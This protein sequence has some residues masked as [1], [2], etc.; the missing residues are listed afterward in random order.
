MDDNERI[1]DEHFKNPQIGDCFHEFYS[2]YLDVIDINDLGI[3]TLTTTGDKPQIRTFAR[4]SKNLFASN[5]MY[6]TLKDK[7]PWTYARTEPSTDMDWEEHKSDS[8]FVFA[9]STRVPFGFRIKGSDEGFSEHSYLIMDVNGLYA[10]KNA[11]MKKQIIN[12]KKVA[13]A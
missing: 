7:Y 12:L 4:D 9:V 1:T 2:V 3:L 8:G 13:Y 10:A 5:H 11:P 6:S